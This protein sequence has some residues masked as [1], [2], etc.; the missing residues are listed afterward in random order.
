[1]SVVV[2]GLFASVLDQ[3]ESSVFA[4]LLLFML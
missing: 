3:M 1:M 2:D 4:G